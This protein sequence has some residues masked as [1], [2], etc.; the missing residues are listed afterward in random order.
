MA[1]VLIVDDE[2]PHVTALAKAFRREGHEVLEAGNGREALELLR[3]TPVNLVITDLMMPE[4]DGLDVLKAV[5]TLFPD[6]EV[7][8]MTAIGTVEKAVEAM[9]L[10]AYDFVTKPV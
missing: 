7:I 8:L 4:M 1:T 5:Q 6:I 9:R 2:L 3:Q 10:G